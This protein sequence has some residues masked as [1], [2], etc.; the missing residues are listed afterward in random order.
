MTDSQPNLIGVPREL[1][2][3]HILTKLPA[4][5]VVAICNSSAYLNQFCQ[6]DSFWQLISEIN[7]PDKI[8]QLNQ[9]WHDLVSLLATEKNIDIYNHKELVG[10]VTIN[11]TATL[12]D[13]YTISKTVIYYLNYSHLGPVPIINSDTIIKAYH[14]GIDYYG[15]PHFIIDLPDIQAAFFMVGINNNIYFDKTFSSFPY[16]NKAKFDI[17]SID[18][19][20]TT[21]L[22]NI[23]LS[24]LTFHYSL[25]SSS[26]TLFDVLTAISVK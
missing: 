8:P 11:K 26:K 7:Y 15:A 19:P 23:K 6:D 4:A 18:L 5:D 16:R 2:K 21:P 20:E 13:L 3:Y 24:T 14:S 9:T 25:I 17:L 22:I 1:L 10:K 12:K